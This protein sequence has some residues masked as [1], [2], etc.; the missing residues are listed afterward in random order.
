MDKASFKQL[1][2]DQR[3]GVWRLFKR[4]PDGSATFREFIERVETPPCDDCVMIQLSNVWYGIEPDG[5]T[6]T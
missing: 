2:K 5:Y 3:H 1:P 4:I 6:H